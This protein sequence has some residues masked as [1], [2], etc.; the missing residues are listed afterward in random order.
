MFALIFFLKIRLL[1][2]ITINYETETLF[3]HH[4]YQC[5]YKTKDNHEDNLLMNK[6]KVCHVRD[7]S[8]KSK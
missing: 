4:Y 7:K 6:Q 8:E 5:L 3:S 1:N 2:S